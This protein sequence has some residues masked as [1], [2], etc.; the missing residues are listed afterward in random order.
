VPIHYAQTSDSLATVQKVQ[1]M[2]LDIQQR[3][4]DENASQKDSQ[5]KRLNYKLASSDEVK[6]KVK[7]QD[8]KHYRE[9]QSD[10]PVPNNCPT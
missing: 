8:E 10:E 4:R 9:V 3:V 7:K 6:L 2:A 5:Q 1:Q